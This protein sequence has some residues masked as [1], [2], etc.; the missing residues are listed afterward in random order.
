MAE[1][2]LLASRD[3]PLRKLHLVHST[4]MIKQHRLT[5]K[6]LDPNTVL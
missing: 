6:V 4:T 3:M 1:T 5:D 2:A